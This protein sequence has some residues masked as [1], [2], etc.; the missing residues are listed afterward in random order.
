VL[1]LYP[2]QECNDQQETDRLTSTLTFSCFTRMK[3]LLLTI[4]I[5]SIIFI[6]FQTYLVNASDKTET[7]AYRV[8]KKEKDFEIRFYPSSTLATI[9]SD[10][11]SYKQ[12]GRSGFRQLASY[13]FGGNANKQ[14]IA[15][16]AP[17][18]M[19]VGD[20]GSSMSFV[21]PSEMNTSNLPQPND[22]GV[23]VH[24][25]PEEYAAVITFG[26]FASDDDIR[27]YS[28]KLSALLKAYSIERTGPFRYLG[29]N[30]PYQLANRRNE[31][32]VAVRWEK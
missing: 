20:S 17:V 6:L 12:L 13:I 4:S 23:M 5:L 1:D 2:I 8:V 3:I 9:K 21:M 11:R 16:T 7:Q 30:P 32:I 25:T 27:Q 18:H 22:P 15:M 29:Y 10:A 19:E 28:D 14:E 24:S 26:G 31:I